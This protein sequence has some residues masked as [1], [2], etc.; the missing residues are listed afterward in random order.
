[1]IPADVRATIEAHHDRPPI[2]VMAV[3]TDFG[4][5]VY[6][7]RLA[8]DVSGLLLRDDSY[9]AP[10]GFVIFVNREEPS[11][12]QRFTAAHELGHFVLHRDFIGD[13]LEDNYLLRSAGLSNR[14]EVEANKFAA[15]LLMPWKLINAAME[16]RIHSPQEMAELFKVSE[17]AMSI[18]LGLV[19]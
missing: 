2:D 12:R 13:R 8:K 19:T 3:A 18:R 7:A 15:D 9:G 10:S 4:V 11:V 14:Q 5:K 1:M 6:S 17:L 16:S